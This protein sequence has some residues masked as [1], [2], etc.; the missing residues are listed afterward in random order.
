MLCSS[1]HLSAVMD[2]PSCSGYL[3]FICVKNG[4]RLGTGTLNLVS[5]DFVLI[6]IDS[7][8]ILP[9]TIRSVICCKNAANIRPQYFHFC[10][11]SNNSSVFQVV[12]LRLRLYLVGHL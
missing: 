7:E 12:I 5:A 6:L 4:N 10:A 1:K 9:G 8:Q 2:K 3:I 11:A